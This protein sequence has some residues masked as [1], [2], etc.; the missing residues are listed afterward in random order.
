MYQKE[1]AAKREYRN[2]S[3]TVAGAGITIVNQINQIA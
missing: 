3:T 1:A 2:G